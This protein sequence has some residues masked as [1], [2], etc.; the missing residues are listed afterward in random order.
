MDN[1]TISLRCFLG[2]V[3]IKLNTILNLHV[4]TKIKMTYI[5]AQ[6]RKMIFPGRLI[7]APCFNLIGGL[8]YIGL[9]FINVQYFQKKK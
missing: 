3:K 5:G 1:L 8:F 9:K 2:Y 7:Q 6:L 4:N